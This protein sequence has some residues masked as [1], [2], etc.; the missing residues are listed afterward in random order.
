MEHRRRILELPS[1]SVSVLDWTPARRTGPDILMLHGGGLDSA[2]LSW[3]ATGRALA[4]AGHRVFAPDHPGFGQSPPASEPVTQERLVAYVGTLVDALRLT[5]YVIGGLSL[6]AGMTLGHL[7]DRPGRACAALL[8]GAYGVMPRLFDGV[9]GRPL[10]TLTWMLVRSGLLPR[11]TRAY[12]RDAPTMERGLRDLIRDPARR[13][14]ELVAA[15]LDEAR[16]PG[17]ETFG[18]WQVDQVLATRLRTDYSSRL[19]EIEVP[20]LL[21]HGDRDTGVPVARAQAAARALPG[22]RIV[23]V[24]D[25]GHWV[26]RD[27]PDLVSTE[28]LAFLDGV[29]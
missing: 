24:P 18:Q 2:Q 1:G 6:G 11:M 13:T 25:A 23:V 17:L 12:A 9:F 3:G 7:L 20:V 28:V 27:R 15:V 21:V 19:G 26:Q 10:H 16:G 4:H 29:R 22:G 14:P 8:F 5:D